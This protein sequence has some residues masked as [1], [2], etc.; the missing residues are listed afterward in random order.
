MLRSRIWRGNTVCAVRRRHVMQGTSSIATDALP[1]G[2]VEAQME[3]NKEKSYGTR[4]LKNFT[5]RLERDQTV[6]ST[7]K[8][9]DDGHAPSRPHCRLALI[10]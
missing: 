6:S 1:E 9:E 10:A 3:L 8:F 5:R 2:L 4:S 7:H